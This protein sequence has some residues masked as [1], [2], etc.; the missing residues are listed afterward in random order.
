MNRDTA[1]PRLILFIFIAQVMIDWLYSAWIKS[2]PDISRSW[3]MIMPLI[4]YF[5]FALSFIASIGL[6]YRNALGVSLACCIL[7]FGSSISIISY[8]FVFN[9]QPLIEMMILPLLILNL[10][11]IF[12]M[13]YNKSYFPK[14]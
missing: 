10:I 9:K 8:T 1:R 2:V 4:F 6:Y 3:F 14:K 12:Y 11:V 7:L 5:Y 13:A